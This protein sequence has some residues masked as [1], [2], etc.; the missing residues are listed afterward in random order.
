MRIFQKTKDGG[1]ESPVTGYF[2]VEIKPLFTIVLL[3]FAGTR[4]AY[5]SHAFNAVTVW[6]KGRVFEQTLGTKYLKLWKAGQ[7]KYT[8]RR[9]MHKILPTCNPSAW[10]ISFRGPW[11]KTWREYRP[12]TE[13]V[14]TLTHG[15]NIV[16]A[17]LGAPYGACK[18]VPPSTVPCL[19]CGAGL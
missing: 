17:A 1:P 14:V 11:A 19:D 8:P 3:H 13:Q 15:R 9:A 5:H 4:E 2:L 18:C 12:L 7:V 10:A 6:L 16:P